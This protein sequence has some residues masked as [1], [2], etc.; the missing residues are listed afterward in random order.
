M[1]DVMHPCELN[2]TGV[3]LMAVVKNIGCKTTGQCLY[4]YFLQILSS[5]PPSDFQR[6]CA[7]LYMCVLHGCNEMIMCGMKRG[8]A[9]QLLYISR[10]EVLAQLNGPSDGTAAGS[11]LWLMMSLGLSQSPQGFCLLMAMSQ[12]EGVGKELQQYNTVCYC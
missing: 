9:R 4:W 3:M 12:E 6:M 11:W 2:L 10:A 7:W 1:D 5:L 8:S